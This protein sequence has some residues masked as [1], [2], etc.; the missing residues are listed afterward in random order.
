MAVEEALV[1]AGR[2]FKTREEL[3][4]SSKLEARG[5][6][7]QGKLG[8]LPNQFDSFSA[9]ALGVRNRF[10]GHG[11]DALGSLLTLGRI[12]TRALVAGD[13]FVKV[14]AYRGALYELAYR[15]ARLA[16]LKGDAFSDHVADFVTSPPGKA[17]EEAQQL[18]RISTLQS[19]LDESTKEL[20]KAMRGPVM[21]WIVP[22][23]KTPMNA[24]FYARDNSPLAF[25]F[26]PYKEAMAQGGAAAAKAQAKMALGT[27]VMGMAAFYASTGNITGSISSDP[28]VRAAYLRRGITP[29]SFRLPGTNKWVPYNPIEPVSTSIGLA[30][31]AYE[32]IQNYPDLVKKYLGSVIP[33][34][35][36]SFAALN[37]A[38]FTD[39]SFVYIPK[40]VRCPVELST[41]FRINAMNTGQF[42]RTLI[43]ADNDSYV[44]YLEGCT[45][46][47][48]DEN[49][50]H[51]ANVELIAL[52]NAEIKYSTVQNWYP[53]DKDGKGGI[54]NFVTKRERVGALIQKYHGH[55]L[56]LDQLLLGSIQA[57]YCKAIIQSVNFIQLQLQTIIKKLTQELR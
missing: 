50:L 36:H 40:G 55:K 26:T 28:K 27:M 29:Y 15:D 37:S 8:T 38:V 41:Y 10:L 33:V 13:S 35:D 23:F 51:A 54:Y 7:A 18:A 46:P 4:G 57:A 30:V 17:V 19:E 52:D 24:I 3:F 20:Q 32:A 21:S 45:A 47:M 16:D 9:G 39:G 56:K 34:T 31:D 6:G 25:A 42:E 12:P 43:I 11:I 2:G 1:A 14:V 22:F 53:G 48:R 44:S 49:Q 5:G